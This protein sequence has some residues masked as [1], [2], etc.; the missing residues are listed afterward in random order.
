MVLSKRDIQFVD[1]SKDLTKEIRELA[2]TLG[3]AGKQ[4]AAAMSQER[5]GTIEQLTMKYKRTLEEHIEIEKTF[6][7]EELKMVSNSVKRGTTPEFLAMSW[8]K[9]LYGDNIDNEPLSIEA[10]NKFLRKNNVD[11]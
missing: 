11:V 7:L 10:L 2:E 6:K 1:L 8:L 5:S 9:I 4:R 3:V